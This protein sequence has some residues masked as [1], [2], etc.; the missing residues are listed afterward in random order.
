MARKLF[1]QILKEAQFCETTEEKVMAL[2]RN[3]N[4]LLRTLL[5][6]AFTSETVYDTEIPS[7]RENSET[8]GYASNNLYVEFRRLYIFKAAEKKV[9][10][11]RKSQLLA[12]VLESI[13][14][15]DAEALI[16]VM[17]KTLGQKYDLTKEVV[18]LAFPNL[19][20]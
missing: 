10:P 1:S 7:Y 20:Q 13:D 19:V 3:D 16:D 18:N 9:A 8:E 2:R 15:P 12:Q 11:K 17:Q 4:P 5:H 6:D 14:A